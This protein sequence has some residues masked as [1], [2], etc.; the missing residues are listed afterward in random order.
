[1][2]SLLHINYNSYLKTNNLLYNIKNNLCNNCIIIINNIYNYIN[3][4][5]RALYEFLHKNNL[6]Y[7]RL[8]LH[9]QSII[10]Q[11]L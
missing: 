1:M 10:I 9:K 8:G 11:I 7:S 5:F 2:I 3:G 4:D 6:N